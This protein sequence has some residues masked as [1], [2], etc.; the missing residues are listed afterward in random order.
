MENKES[1]NELA[2]PL[3]FIVNGVAFE[4]I[5][6][7]GGTF[8]M[9][10][11]EPD[12]DYDEKLIHSVSLCDYSIGKTQVT[13]AL[14]K[15][16]M[17]S[18]PSEIKGENLPVECV[19]WYDCQ[20]FIRKLNVLTGK[21]FRLPT[22]AE[23]EF[24]ARG[25]NK[26]KGYKYSGSDNIDDVAWYWDNSG[27]TT[28]AV[29]TK[30]PNELG[31]YDMSGNVW[32]RCYDWHGNYSIDSQTNPTGPEY[33]FYRIC[34]G[35]SYAS[36]ATSSSMRCLGTPDMGHQYSGLRLVLSDNVIIVTEPNVNHDSLKFNVNGV[37][38]EMVKVEGGTYMMGNNDYMEA[39]TDATP[40]H[41]VTLSSYF[42]CKTVVTQKLWKAVKGYN[43]SWSTGDWQ[44]VEHV[45]WE[46]CQSFISELNRLTGKKFRLPTEAEW[47][48]AARGGNKSKDY[49]YSGS[50]NIDEVAW[51]KGN[52]GDRSHMVATKQPNEL[53]IYDMSGSVLEWCFDWYG[54]Y[55]SGFQTNPEGPAFGFRRVVRGGL[56]FEDERYC[57]VSN[58]EYHFAPDFEYQWLGFRLAL[59]LTSDSSDE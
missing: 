28:H 40:S 26:S 27:K 20:E 14:W 13:Q 9:G 36:S 49:K 24:A 32:E 30:M 38:F 5:N 15:A 59:D 7:E 25:G 10:N 2:V 22:E 47:E 56:W 52:S 23:W 43:P 4:M 51:Y 53:G 50:D 57:H 3:K 37:S 58:R 11:T 54:E 45:S 33:G 35:G 19:S 8:Q 41:S 55:N 34:R 6:V 39:G 29:A 44:P 46:N 18:N 42:I 31:I 48:F 17:G 16:V 1:I 21:T 12:A